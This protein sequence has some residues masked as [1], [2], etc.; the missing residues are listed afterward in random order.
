M[1]SGKRKI[2]LGFSIFFILTILSF[3][4]E[5]I[6][7]GEEIDF[8]GLEYKK[9]YYYT[10]TKCFIANVNSKNY[11]ETYIL[12]SRIDSQ[13]V[14]LSVNKKVVFKIG[15]LEAVS[16]LWGNS[17]V[18]PVKFSKGTNEVALCV[19]SAERMKVILPIV[20]TDHP[21]IYSVFFKI[22]FVGIVYMAATILL[23]G[24]IF[25]FGMTL[26][27]GIERYYK[28]MS[29][30]L[31]ISMFFSALFLTY[32]FFDLNYSTA[33]FELFSKK[34]V[35]S[36]LAWAFYFYFHVLLDLA[37]IKINKVYEYLLLASVVALSIASIIAPYYV[38]DRWFQYIYPFIFMAVIS[39]PIF[40]LYKY[41]IY[42]IFYPH[43]VF[44][45]SI[46]V[47]FLS[48]VFHSYNHF[49][50]IY[51]IIYMYETYIKEAV[52]EFK[53]FHNKLVYDTLT[54]AFSRIVLGDVDPKKYD[55]IV[56]F[57]IND[58]K[59]YNDTMGHKEGDYILRKV[60]EVVKRN[61]KG[62]DLIIR[63]G[64]DEFVV[65]IKDCDKEFAKTLMEKIN[66]EF[67]EIY[68]KGISYGISTFE[69]SLDK[70]IKEADM[71]MY[72]M[73][74]M[75]KRRIGSHVI[76]LGDIRKES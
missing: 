17:I 34:M 16:N 66:K 50:L 9:T 60:V 64:G 32:Y 38:F 10:G 59:L 11:K 20:I 43:I 49:V 57:D 63:Y 51:G 41:R 40:K 52:I 15:S 35:L 28:K 69:G 56:F 76:E 4:P 3:F 26:L 55:A 72:R 12:L 2:K 22:S 7:I 37:H 29:M 73:K 75:Y 6:R 33:S 19:D 44:I 47:H 31:S 13:G 36:F 8:Q 5:Y 71:D 58:F 27:K 14:T 53:N 18:V 65:V 39:I 1:T 46:I 61:I 24:S 68:P 30:K 70:A 54:G 21:W 45:I 74:F 48:C 42:H 67:K 25:F 62:K 23:F